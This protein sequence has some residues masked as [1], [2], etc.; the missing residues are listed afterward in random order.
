MGKIQAA[1]AECRAYSPNLQRNYMA[2]VFADQDKPRTLKIGDI[3]DTD[4]FG[5]YNA[6]RLCW[7]LYQMAYGEQ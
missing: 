4:T 3:I 6:H 2:E 1:T 5:V 7:K